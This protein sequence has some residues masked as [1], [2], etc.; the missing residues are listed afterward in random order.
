M[1]KPWHEYWLG[2]R[3]RLLASPRF[4]S[5]AAAFPPTRWIAR[6]RA[7]ALFDLCAGFVYSQVLL[8]CVR[9]KVFDALRDG[10]LQLAELAARLSLAP[11]AAE[12]LM[13][14]AC[15]LGLAERRGPG[16]YGLGELGAS[17]VDHPAITAMVE[18]HELLYADLADPVALL[19]AGPGSTRLAQYWAYATSPAPQTLGREHV[20][21][22]S[23]LMSAS[24]SWIAEEVL[25]AYSMR[26]HRHLLDVGG[27]AG[28]FLAA[29][30][31]RWPHL[32]LAL[33][34]LPAVIECAGANLRR[35]GCADRISLHGGNFL[36]EALPSGADLV[37]LVRV[38]H[39]HEERKVTALLRAVHRALAPG[40]AVLIAEPMA[41]T[42]GAEVVGAAY[43]GFY[44]WAMGGQGEA[45]E[46]NKIK[47][48][49]ES[50][51]FRQVRLVST[52]QPLQTGL[53]VA[54][55]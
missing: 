33:F 30:A 9:L 1:H 22:Y 6:R 14:A 42:A 45:R 15:S 47:E 50:A 43:F 7:R 21:A 54:Q 31:R 41:G 39:D 40:G 12:R 18:H 8:A 25:A 24:Q 2:L 55:K 10:P 36:S 37:T 19:R 48:L 44:L 46:F 51:G 20:A 38:L 5:W 13:L 29:V 35:A 32:R 52:R 26:R 23:G 49:L 34:D 27:G 53:V 16:R 17:V 11:A 4:R 28:T 3:D